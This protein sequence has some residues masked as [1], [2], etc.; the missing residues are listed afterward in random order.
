MT[1]YFVMNKTV[2]AG[3]L[4][5]SGFYM[6]SKKKSVQYYSPLQELIS[7]NVG[8]EMKVDQTN[9]TDQLDVL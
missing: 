6:D 7:L 2:S 5:R 1:F 3:I 9:S 8:L 4:S